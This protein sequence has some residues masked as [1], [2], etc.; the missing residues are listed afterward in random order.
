MRRCARD[1]PRGTTPRRTGPRRS[2]ATRGTTRRPRGRRR[3]TPAAFV[4]RSAW[5][6]DDGRSFWKNRLASGRASEEAVPFV[7]FVYR[8]R[9]SRKRS[10]KH[11]PLRE[12]E[13]SFSNARA[14]SSEPVCVAKVSARSDARRSEPRERLPPGGRRRTSREASLLSRRARRLGTC[15]SPLLRA[16]RGSADASSNEASAEEI[17]KPRC[18]KRLVRREGDRARLGSRAHASAGTPRTVGRPRS[19]HARRGYNAAVMPTAIP[20]AVPRITARRHPK[21]A[22]TAH[23]KRA[24]KARVRPGGEDVVRERPRAEPARLVQLDEERLARL[25]LAQRREQQQPAQAR[26]RTGVARR[27]EDAAETAARERRRSPGGGRGVVVDESPD[28]EPA[29][30]S[31]VS[32]A[33]GARSRSADAPARRPGATRRRPAAAVPRRAWTCELS[34]RFHNRQL[35]FL[36]TPSER[37]HARRRDG[38]RGGGLAVVTLRGIVGLGYEACAAML[39]R[40]NGDVAAAVNRHFAAHDPR[41][42]EAGDAVVFVVAEAEL[43]RCA[44]A[45]REQRRREA[46]HGTES[47]VEHQS[48]LRGWRWPSRHRLEARGRVESADA[49]DAPACVRGPV[50][51]TRNRDAGHARRSRRG[52]RGASGADRDGPTMA[53]HVSVARATGSNTSPPAPGGRGA[54]PRRTRLEIHRAA[55]TTSTAAPTSAS[56]PYAARAT[57]RARLACHGKKP[58]SREARRATTRRRERVIA[59]APGDCLAVTSCAMYERGATP[60]IKKTPSSTAPGGAAARRTD[61]TGASNDRIARAHDK[62]GQTSATSRRRSR[63]GQPRSRLDRWTMPRPPAAATARRNIEAGADKGSAGERSTRGRP[64]CDARPRARDQIPSSD[65]SARPG[66]NRIAASARDLAEAAERAFPDTRRR[67]RVYD[68]HDDHSRE[69]FSERE[70]R[71]RRHAPFGEQLVSRSGPSRAPFDRRG[72]RGRGA[73]GAPAAGQ[74]SRRTHAGASDRTADPAAKMRGAD[75]GRRR[76]FWRSTSTTACARDPPVPGTER[77]SVAA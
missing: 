18:L 44:R 1:A 30:A 37:R 47:A 31:A 27:A 17:G 6:T 7:P 26:G 64:C 43:E 41:G 10:R 52:G 35:L 36:T 57:L 50:D 14:T 32:S 77:Q 2:R 28:A 46:R 23:T 69:T 51:E 68:G 56:V 73:R 3:K 55:T 70:R 63:R 22:A 9:C 33:S 72:R 39:A 15:A 29:G 61:V 24:M 25:E 20:H 74:A 12:M 42:D 45:Q 65:L 59:D 49:L 21:R 60:R 66:A 54:G 76:L 19:S 58:T 71:R 38:G 53:L 62:L 16:F 67:R 48:A 75:A 11:P 40:A 34:A 5:L 4:S 13:M 8:E